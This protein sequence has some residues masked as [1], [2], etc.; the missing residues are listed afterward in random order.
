MSA[1]FTCD[2]LLFAG[3]PFGDLRRV[4]AQSLATDSWAETFGRLASSYEARAVVAERDHFTETARELWRYVAIAHQA[5]SFETHLSPCRHHDYQLMEGSRRK[6]RAA[7]RNSLAHETGPG[8]LR[9]VTIRAAGR[10]LE[11]YFRSPRPAAPCVVLVNGLDSIAE[12]ELQAFARWFT[13]R[14]A[15]VLSLNIPVDYVTTDRSPLV[16]ARALVSPICDWLQSEAGAR[17]S[18]VFGVSFGG[19]LVAQ[20]LS[21]DTRIICGAAV[22]PPAFITPD[23]LRLERIRVMWACALRRSYEDAGTG[24]Q[25]LPDVRDLNAPLGDALLIGCHDDPVFGEE[26]L[27]AYRKWGRERLSV[28]MLEAEHVATSRYSDWLPDACDW[29]C[30]RLTSAALERAA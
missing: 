17:Q 3:L 23:E 12:V 9:A 5:A 29:I 28:R 22:C 16:D 25:D 8:G 6:A 2:R 26:H 1:Q 7:F 20:F 18:G 11:G 19:H 21:E 15:A 30:G 10:D 13:A 24:A 27:A 14:G 4:A